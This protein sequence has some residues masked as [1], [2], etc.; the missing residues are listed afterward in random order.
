M[1][2]IAPII[3]CIRVQALHYRE[4]EFQNL[5]A[6]RSSPHRLVEALVSLHNSL[7]QPEAALGVLQVMS[8]DGTAASFLGCFISW[9]AL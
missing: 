4:I 9:I 5:S 7:S 1:P 2:W 6:T 3:Y 8:N